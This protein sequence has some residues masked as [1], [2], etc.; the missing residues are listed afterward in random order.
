MVGHFLWFYEVV[1]IWTE[2]FVLLKKNC[3]MWSVW[4]I[5][6]TLIYQEKYCVMSRGVRSPF[7]P[8]RRSSPWGNFSDGGLNQSINQ[9]YTFIVNLSVDWLIDEKLTLTWLAYWSRTARSVF[10]GA[11]LKWLNIT[12]QYRVFCFF[13]FLSTFQ[14]W[15][16]AQNKLRLGDENFFSK[17]SNEWTA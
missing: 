6:T 13:D 12:G 9:A 11:G 4:G 8:T 17:I 10:T 5:W 2:N 7:G 14:R 16:F 1:L 15:I 3:R